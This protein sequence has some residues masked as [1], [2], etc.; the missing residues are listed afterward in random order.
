MSGTAP[1]KATPAPSVVTYPL[2]TMAK[3]LLMT[4]RNLNLL[5]QRGIIPRAERGR[6]ELIPCLHAYIRYIRD[7]GGLNG[8][9]GGRADDATSPKG[10]IIT[11]RA[12]LVE[13]EA[14][15]MTREVFRSAHVV[16]AWVAILDAVRTRLRAIPSSVAPLWASAMTAT[17]AQAAVA[18][19]IN[20]VLSEL[21]RVPVYSTQEDTADPNSR[22][23]GAGG[24]G[25][26]G[27][28]GAGAAADA[29]GEPVG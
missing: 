17:E 25:E 6:Y 29:D 11:A 20:D 1:D 10:R 4:E 2:G 19:S 12:K 8:D 13:T 23:G 26:D 28:A 18:R 16:G 9:A 3:A 14:A 5:V 27:D 21:S 15:L 24:G 7:R 22:P